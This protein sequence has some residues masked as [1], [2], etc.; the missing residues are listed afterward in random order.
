[1]IGSTGRTLDRSSL[2]KNRPNEVP[3]VGGYHRGWL[4]Q[5]LSGRT[6]VAFVHGR[7]A[8]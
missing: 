7:K 8:G 1:M 3:T 2:N 4:G 5:V 6:G